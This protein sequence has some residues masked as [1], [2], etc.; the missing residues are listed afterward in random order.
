MRIRGTKPEFWKSRRIA[1]I[2]TEVAFDGPFPTGNKPYVDLPR[3]T[4]NSRFVYLLLSSVGKPVYIGRSWRPADRF[5]S[6]RRKSWWSQVA[7]LVIIRVSG[8]SPVEADVYTARVEQVL[9]EELAPSGNISAGHRRLV[10]DGTYT[11]Y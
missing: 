2:P 5:S 8:A 1:S 6:H 4:G 7:H 9:I 11:K 10:P 3:A